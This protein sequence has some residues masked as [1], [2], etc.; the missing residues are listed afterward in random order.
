MFI[1]GK[2]QYFSKGNGEPVIVFITGLGPTMDDLQQ[3]K[4]SY[5]KLIE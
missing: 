1:R 2:K 5:R 3:Y 4:I